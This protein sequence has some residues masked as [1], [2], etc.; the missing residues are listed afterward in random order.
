MRSVGS[1]KYWKYST[2]N[3]CNRGIKH[4][5]LGSL[6]IFNG[7]YKVTFTLQCDISMFI[8]VSAVTLA[9]EKITD[10]KNKFWLD[11]DTRPFFPKG[12]HR[13][14]TRVSEKFLKTPI[15][16]AQQ[17]YFSTFGVFGCK[18]EFR[19]SILQALYLGE[20]KSQRAEGTLRLF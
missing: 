2:N 16:I 20:Q 5:F 8:S 4:F 6:D 14:H 1:Y 9:V 3:T 10:G 15:K 19:S 13:T 11:K 18:L 12:H 17:Y 7:T